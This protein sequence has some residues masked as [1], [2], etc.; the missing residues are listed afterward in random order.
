MLLLAVA[1]AADLIS[2]IYR[3]TMLQV[4]ATDEMRGQMQ[5]AF[6]VVVAGGPRLADIWHGPT[7]AAVGPGT[8]TSSAPASTR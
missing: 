7:A 4:V 6:F 5:G 8:A 2:A 3:V 1:G